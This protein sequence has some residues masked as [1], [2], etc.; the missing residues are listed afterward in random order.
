MWSLDFQNKNSSLTDS[1]T[2]KRIHASLFQLFTQCFFL[3]EGSGDWTTCTNSFLFSLVNPVGVGP[4]K[5]ALKADQKRYGIYCDNDT[6]PGFGSGTDLLINNAANS[7]TSSSSNLG[8]TYECPPNQSGDT[9][10]AGQNNFTVNEYEVF[11]YQR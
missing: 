10:L 2:A 3:S 7:N 9:F 1:I 4:T 5:M 8:H 11:G 6:G